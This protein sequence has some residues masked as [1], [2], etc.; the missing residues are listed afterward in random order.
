MAD[1]STFSN[2]YSLDCIGVEA[3]GASCLVE[4]HT[5]NADDDI[6]KQKC[7]FNQL[8]SVYLKED[9]SRGIVRP[10]P[11]FLGDGKLLDLYELFSLVKE[12]GGYAVVSV[13]G[14]WG[15]V[16]KELGLN[17]K[18]LASVKLVYNKYLN[19]FEGWLR[20]T[21][22]ENS[23]KNENHLSDWG[24]KS[25]LL[26]L[27]KEFRCLLCPKQKEKDDELFLLES[28][29]IRNYI[30]LVNHKSDTNLLDAKYQIIKCEGVPLV[31]GDDDEN[32]CNC[33]KDDLATTLAEVAEK[34]FNS[35]KRKRE[36]LSGMLN[37]MKQIAKNPLDPV[38]ELI[39]KPSKWKEYKGQ[40]FFVQ[41]MR[42]RE[43]LSLRQ[44]VEP[45]SGPS[46]L[47]K[48]KMHPSIYEDHVGHH[49]TAKL[50]CSRRLPTCVKSRS[51]SGCNS[52]S[53]NGKRLEISVNTEAE[54]CPPEKTTPMAEP[55]GD[56]FLKKQVSIG[57]LFQAEIPEWTGVISES[58]PKWLGTQVWPLKHDS[59]P[60]TETDLIGRGRQEKCSCQFQ[61][62]VECVRFH[63][64]ENRMK[65][66]LAL[67]SVFYHWGFDR[68]GEEVSL[69]WTTE[70]EKKFKD[71]MRSKIPSQGRSFW[72]NSSKYF[73]KKTRR[74]L[75]SYYFNV[76]LIQLRSYQNRV[77]PKSVDS[78][79]DEVEFGS[80]SDGFGMEAIKGP[81]INFLECSENKQC[82]DLE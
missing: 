43:V 27:E 21:F 4:D 17:L 80:L 61:G 74:N 56:D 25:S 46:S 39:P 32:F 53:T 33:V 54:K 31:N 14:L 38:T 81:R 35:R 6:V 57:P 45:N 51:C 1:L 36:A 71:I 68:M 66:K 49:V 55:A 69:Q 9:C 59:K 58:D 75:V 24:F 73:R 19:D 77:T 2:G 50:R 29:K 44:P 40:N 37:W 42:A 72:N 47:Q 20:K 82:T 62:S 8:F 76:F 48:L 63:I 16:T 18:I 34:E 12:R 10:V 41:L 30:D 5:D 13:K 26:E 15:D 65:L 60:S 11:V 64:A 7:L 3:D 28:N 70:E 23:F 52:C 79:D 78:D 67:G 22:E